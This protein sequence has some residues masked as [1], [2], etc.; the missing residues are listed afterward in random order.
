MAPEEGIRL[1]ARRV[2]DHKLVDIGKLQLS[3][4]ALQSHCN[5]VDKELNAAFVLEELKKLWSF[6]RK[7]IIM[8]KCLLQIKK[9]L[10]NQSS[11]KLIHFFAYFYF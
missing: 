6:P 3:I 11:F 7:V 9:S 8:W 5:P 2:V 4:A 10:L 1:L